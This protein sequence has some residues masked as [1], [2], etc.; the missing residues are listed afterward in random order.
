MEL[1]VIMDI[2]LFI[3]PVDCSAVSASLSALSEK[4]QLQQPDQSETFSALLKDVAQNLF[5]EQLPAFSDVD[6]PRESAS[7]AA[8][9]D[10]STGG[11]LSGIAVASVFEARD[12]HETVFSSGR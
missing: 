7:L 9:G 5:E 6:D 11:V 12:P 10:S 4:G 3:A 1:V 8:A 2:G